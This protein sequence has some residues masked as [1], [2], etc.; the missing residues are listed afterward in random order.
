MQFSPGCE[1]RICGCLFHRKPKCPYWLATRPSSS[2]SIAKIRF[3]ACSD[4]PKEQMRDP[5]REDHQKHEE[6]G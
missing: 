3:P 6:E 4:P 1:R 2:I 5:L